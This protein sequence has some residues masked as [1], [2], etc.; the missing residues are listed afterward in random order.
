MRERTAEYHILRTMML[1]RSFEEALQRRRDHG[2]QLL[3]SGEEAVAV[4]ICANLTSDDQLLCSGRSIAPALAR[5]LDPC[6]VM[7]ELVGKSAGPCRGKGGRGHLAAPALGF[8]GAHAVVGGNLTI[9]AG[10]ALA[11]QQQRKAGLVACIFGDGACGSGALHETLN[12][13]A[14]WRLPLLLIC[15]NNQYSVSTPASAVLAPRALATLAL[16]FGIPSKTVDGMDILAV[17][18][19]VQDLAANIRSGAGPAF[20]ECISYRFMTHS[21]AT[22]ETRSKAEIAEWKARCPILKLASHLAAHG[23]LSNEEQNELARDVATTIA[24]AVAFA[25]A[26][27]SPAISEALTDVV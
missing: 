8:F 15:N 23:K 3:S 9:A 2:F 24:D 5:G 4:G 26:A 18:K 16:P 6:A 1:I 27:P 19:A 21:T 14:I 7:A 22:R 10:V 13:A 12:M 25:D 17:R 11:M 20:L